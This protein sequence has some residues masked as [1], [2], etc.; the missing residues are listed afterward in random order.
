MIVNDLFL[1]CSIASN[2]KL[3]KP[4][5]DSLVTKSVLESANP[6]SGYRG[7]EG[8]CQVPIKSLIH[9]SEILYLHLN[10]LF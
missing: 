1:W 2:P 10:F 3:R 4:C 5:L 7:S 6:N 8:S 9:S